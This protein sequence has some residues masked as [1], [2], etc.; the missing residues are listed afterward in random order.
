MKSLLVSEVVC[1]VWSIA[2]GFLP[3][4]EAR[5]QNSVSIPI[6]QRAE[7]SSLSWRAGAH[8][9]VCELAVWIELFLLLHPLINTPL[10]ALQQ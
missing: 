1:M 8:D 2:I 6:S 5:R 7:P 10:L 9:N 4:G 3:P